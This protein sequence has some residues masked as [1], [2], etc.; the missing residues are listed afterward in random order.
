VEVFFWPGAVNPSGSYRLRL[1]FGGND[2]V[3]L[4]TTANM[5]DF[6]LASANEPGLWCFIQFAKTIRAKVEGESPL[7]LIFGLDDVTWILNNLQRCASL[8]PR[9]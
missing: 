7:E 9:P 4:A 8:L 6:M 2:T 5:G 3:T 1:D